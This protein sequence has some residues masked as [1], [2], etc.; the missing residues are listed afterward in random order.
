MHMLAQPLY[1]DN[2]EEWNQYEEEELQARNDVASI[3]ADS[4]NRIASFL[5]E[6]TVIGCTT[7][8]IK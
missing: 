1:A 3:A 5:G 8:L 6:K 4:I 2:L 7:H